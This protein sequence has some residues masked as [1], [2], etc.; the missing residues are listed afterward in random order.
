MQGGGLPVLGQAVLYRRW[1]HPQG[2][3]GRHLSRGPGRA[4]R[5][6]EF[7]YQSDGVADDEKG[8]D[9]FT[10]Q[11]QTPRIVTNQTF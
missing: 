11:L 4:G 1:R 10:N 8:A 3:A 6:H 7:T 2:G 9:S 5:H